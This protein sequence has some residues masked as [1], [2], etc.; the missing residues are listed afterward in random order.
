MGRVVAQQSADHPLDLGDPSTQ[1]AIVDAA[2]AEQREFEE[3]RGV[4]H[5]DYER[6]LAIFIRHISE[7][8]T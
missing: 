7:A 5:E 1:A 4:T 8:A 2:W 3:S 6:W